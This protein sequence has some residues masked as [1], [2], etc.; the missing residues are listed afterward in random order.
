MMLLATTG[1]NGISI[2]LGSKKTKDQFNKA[3]E[4]IMEFEV[5]AYD[6]KLKEDDK[7]LSKSDYGK[8]VSL[9]DAEKKYFIEVSD[10]VKSL[11]KK[12]KEVLKSDLSLKETKDIV[13]VGKFDQVGDNLEKY[14]DDFIDDIEQLNEENIKELEK[15][16][17]PEEYKAIYVDSKNQLN[18]CFEKYMSEVKSGTKVI[19]STLKE[20]AN[21]YNEMVALKDEDK[22]DEGLDKI[23]ML[24]EETDEV[25]SSS[26]EQENKF[27]EEVKKINQE[28]KK[29]LEE[30]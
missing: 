26:D 12:Y 29:K 15:L 21:I 17:I 10:G 8:F 18:D 28:L 7:K 6:G 4:K 14:V 13:K 24:I 25:V 19:S 22:I 11:E 16:N 23:L 20:M 3:M 5:K 1:C 27:K 9:I 30:L 2:K